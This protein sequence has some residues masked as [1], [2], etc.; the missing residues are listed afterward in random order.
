MSRGST[1]W[2]LLGLLVTVPTGC[3]AS[4]VVAKEQRLVT[5]DSTQLPW[6]PATVATLD[7]LYESV[8]IRGDAAVSLRRIWYVFTVGGSYTGAALADADGQLAFQTLSGSWSL[9]PGGL[10][11]DGQEAVPCDAAEGHLR[12]SAPTGVVILKKV[13]LQ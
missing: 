8:D 6:V 13:T 11:L 7:G 10:V 4:N 1:Y 2:P 5:T 9:A 12:L 3:I